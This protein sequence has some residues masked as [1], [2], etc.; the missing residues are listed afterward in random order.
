M[1]MKSAILTL[2][3]CAM[4]TQVS[5]SYREV[6]FDNYT[7]D[8][9]ICQEK[10][11]EVGLQMMSAAHVNIVRTY[12]QPSTTESSRL[13][14]VVGYQGSS[15]VAITSAANDRYDGG[16]DVA[17]DCENDLAN[18]IA[19]FTSATGLAPLLSYCTPEHNFR[20]YALGSSLTHYYAFSIRLDSIL[21]WPMHDPELTD[22]TAIEAAIYQA[23]TS[24]GM[25][26]AR[27]AVKSSPMTGS[28]LYVF[29]YG[30]HHDFRFG[31]T[32]LV[33]L[34]TLASC[35]Q[36]KSEISRIVALTGVEPLVPFCAAE[37]NDFDHIA[38]L[39]MFGTQTPANPS[40][41]LGDYRLQVP[42]KEVVS[43]QYAHLEDCRIEQGD[44]EQ[45]EQ[46]TTSRLIVGSACTLP[47]QERPVV[48][49]E[50]WYFRM[51]V[52]YNSN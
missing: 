19:R 8:P 13:S 27:V 40:S 46:A 31:A 21:S 17:A 20:I 28:A 39:Y 51:L 11:S 30:E 1:K 43:H 12:C 18:Q 15:D 26:L 44:V 9:Q 25:N 35:E 24:K 37:R 41:P 14:L 7:S 16:Y 5:A 22:A 3:L 45:E 38:T 4:S 23:L 42:L 47:M 36:H 34:P 33:T 2:G 48:M 32:A 52:F 10:A 29:Y 6:K 49:G 50:P